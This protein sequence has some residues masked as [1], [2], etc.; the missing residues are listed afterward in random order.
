MTYFDDLAPCTYL[1]PCSSCVLAV[2]VKNLLVPFRSVIYA[3]PS[4]IIHYVE[5]HGYQPPEA[6][7]VALR[8]LDPTAAHY[9]AECERLWYG[10]RVPPSATHPSGGRP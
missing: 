6:F 2:G 1:G 10:A 5:A 8:A 7:V 3:A 4:L 9:R